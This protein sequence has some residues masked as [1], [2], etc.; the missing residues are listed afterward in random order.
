MFSFSFIN[1]VDSF[2]PDMLRVN[3]IFELI[4]EST[5]IPMKGIINIAFLSDKEICDLNREFREKDKTT[6]VLSFHYFDEF[7]S[8]EDDTVAGEIVLSESKI[9]SQSKEYKH[10]L[11]EECEILIIHSLLHIL[12]FDHE[13]D[14]DFEDMWEYESFIREKMGLSIER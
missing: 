14:D 3:M 8:L 5:K 11:Q 2:A 1:Q 6:D 13:E 7:D 10:S 9:Q 12:G 4:Q